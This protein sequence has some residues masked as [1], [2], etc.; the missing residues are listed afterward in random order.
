MVRKAVDGN[1]EDEAT[2]QVQLPYTLF[3]PSIFNERILLGLL[4]QTESS[5]DICFNAF[6]AKSILSAI[7]AI[8][9]N[10]QEVKIRV[11]IDQ[12]FGSKESAPTW[13]LGCYEQVQLC[14][15]AGHTPLSYKFVIID[16]KIVIH[17]SFAWT[18][19]ALYHTQGSCHL[20]KECL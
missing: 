7:Q 8:A 12:E 9:H 13:R 3:F 4:S 17:S 6:T 10:N 2:V 16:D 15:S 14:F 11:L 19:Q 18:E 1:D 20:S 5:L